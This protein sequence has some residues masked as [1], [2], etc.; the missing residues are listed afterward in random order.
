MRLKMQTKKQLSRELDFKSRVYNKSL[1][2]VRASPLMPSQRRYNITISHS[3][4]FI[5]FRVAKVATR[6]IL[7]E[8]KNKGANLDAEHPMSIHYPINSYQN[9]YKF[10]FVRNPWDRLVSCWL[11][12]IVDR[13][14]PAESG[15]VRWNQL[16]NQEPGELDQFHNFVDFVATQEIENCDIHLRQ[17]SSLIDLNSIDF[18][19]RFE[20]LG[21][22]IAT[23]F[24][25][26][27]L[28]QPELG[29]KNRSL[30][31]RDYRDYYTDDLA[32]QVYRIYERDIRIFNYTFD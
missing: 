27:G 22:D 31:R 17:Q 18:L 15:V 32:E 5:W 28:T 8:L 25:A 4:R 13:G 3:D 23:I 1:K 9:Y 14:K 21:A 20:N 6:S 29:W 24:N 30:G 7:Q 12:K 11:N 16:S 26:I 10:A 19:G 2:T